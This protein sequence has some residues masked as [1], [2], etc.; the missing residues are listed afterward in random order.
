MVKIVATQPLDFFPDQKDRLNK[1]GDVKFYDDMPKTTKEWLKRVEGSDV[2]CSG[3]FGLKKEWENLRDV[4]VSLPF[5]GVGWADPKILKTNNIVMSS[6]PGC[7]RHAVSEWIIAM[8]LIMARQL[9]KYMNAKT[10]SE[11]QLRTP[12][13]GLAFKNV[14]VLGK[15]NIGSRVGA[16]CEALEMSVSYYR[17][18]DD[19][20]KKTKNADI[21]VDT[22]SLNPSTQNL[23]NNDFFGSLKEGAIFISITGETIVDID[24]MLATLDSGKLR[25][26]AHDS[27]GIQVGDAKDP[28]YQKLLK[29]P[30]VYVTPHVSYNT[31]V[32]RRVS[33]DMMIDNVEAYLKGKPINL[34]S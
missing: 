8:M 12:E 20:E 6:S 29:H 32:E 19:L 21:V 28:F 34:V 30:R 1:L 22:L 9:D 31:D 2:I 25:Y 14:T 11:E 24:A 13:M 27:G 16:V 18:G 23:L 5:V 26:V 15:G 7:N 17:R 4:F 10:V 33:N 3:G